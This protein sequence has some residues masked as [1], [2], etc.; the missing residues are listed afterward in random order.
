MRP[1]FE[2]FS[3]SPAQEQKRNNPVK[4]FW[5]TAYFTISGVSLI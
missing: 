5:L 4:I 1:I 3:C 2:T